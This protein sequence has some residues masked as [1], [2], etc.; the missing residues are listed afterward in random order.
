ML[1]DSTNAAA[2]GGRSVE[3]TYQK[4]S[5]REHILIRPDTYG[6]CAI[7]VKNWCFPVA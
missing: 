7:R 2:G 6:T 1:E 5:Q 4:K 3:Q